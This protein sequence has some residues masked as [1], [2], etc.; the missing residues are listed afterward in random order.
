MADSGDSAGAGG[1]TGGANGPGGGAGSP[2]GEASGNAG[3]GDNNN[4]GF[5]GFGAFNNAQR[6]SELQARI[7]AA[8]ERARLETKALFDNLNTIEQV[9]TKPR[10]AREKAAADAKIAEA[11]ATAR[12]EAIPRRDTTSILEQ[13][14]A[15]IS[16][17]GAATEKNPD[18]L[19]TT[20]AGAIARL[21][22]QI[23]S[24]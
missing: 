13:A 22:Q 16:A 7:D 10:L 3:G 2:D 21:V 8:G 19:L 9:I 15:V 11:E 23:Q 17:T 12:V 18:V 4:R 24:S 14:A 1:G 6:A 20:E 5:S